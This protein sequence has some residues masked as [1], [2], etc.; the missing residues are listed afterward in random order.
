MAVQ[1]Q[2]RRGSH[3]CFLSA[4]SVSSLLTVLLILSLTL[5]RVGGNVDEDG[6]GG[7]AMS[8]QEACTTP[9]GQRLRN[10]EDLIFRVTAGEDL[11]HAIE[12]FCVENSLTE[13]QCASVFPSLRVHGYDG[14]LKGEQEVS[15]IIQLERVV[16]LNFNVRVSAADV[17]PI[18]V[19]IGPEDDV[20]SISRSICARLS[21]AAHACAGVRTELTASAI[22][23]LCTHVPRGTSGGSISIG[24]VGTPS[25]SPSAR[26]LQRHSHHE[27]PTEHIRGALKRIAPCDKVFVDL[28]SWRGDSLLKFA[29]ASQEDAEGAEAQGLGL[30]GWINENVGAQTA[31]R[32]PYC[33]VGFEGNSDFTSDLE[34]TRHEMVREGYRVA[35]FTETVVSDVDGH[36]RF[37]IDR[38]SEGQWGSSLRMEHPDIIRTDNGMPGMASSTKVKST[39]LGT[40]LSELF[41]KH[42]EGKEQLWQAKGAGHDVGNAEDRRGERRVI[43]KMDIEGAEYPILKDLVTSGAACALTAAGVSV[44]ILLELHPYM[45][46]VFWPHAPA[47]TSTVLIHLLRSC[48]VHVHTEEG[49][50]D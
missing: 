33:V 14:L 2:A 5:P 6:A 10:Y 8:L 13:A 3:A 49:V 40:F 29:R 9:T 4:F 50:T 1:R 34:S 48:G 12:N 41:L 37:F 19:K 20:E 22:E 43:I 31:D 30:V 45:E 25:P 46:P 32:L 27:N 44:H 11:Q 39:R 17:E 24:S 36:V 7:V 47:N 15:Q 38:S 42:D 23:E 16:D 28:G 18:V 21:L 26:P 35:I